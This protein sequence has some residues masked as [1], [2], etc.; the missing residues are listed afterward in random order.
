[1]WLA[2]R[3]QPP[4]HLPFW[5][6]CISLISPVTPHEAY[7]DSFSL[8]ISI[9][10]LLVYR[11]RLLVG[12]AFVS[13]LPL[14]S[15]LTNSVV[16][17]SDP[18]TW[19]RRKERL[20]EGFSPSSQFYWTCDFARRTQTVLEPFDSHGFPETSTN[21]RSMIVFDSLKVVLPRFM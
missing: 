10:P 2:F 20:R 15:L 8:S 3:D 11:F 17:V 4:T 1:M 19:E 7:D 13:C 14:F 12:Q 21:F 16:R 5:F 18:F 9:S 6:R